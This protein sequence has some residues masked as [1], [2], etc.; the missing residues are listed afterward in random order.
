MLSQSI[1]EQDKKYFINKTPYL[2]E[3]FLNIHLIKISLILYSACV[4][5]HRSLLS[6]CV[7]MLRSLE[8]YPTIFGFILREQSIRISSHCTDT[9]MAT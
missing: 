4:C 3:L 2:S 9:N 7:P 8:Y 6:L 1:L 5:M